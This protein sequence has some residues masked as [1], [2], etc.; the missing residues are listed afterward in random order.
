LTGVPPSPVTYSNPTLPLSP[1]AALSPHDM[2]EEPPGGGF[3]LPTAP[4]GLPG[5]T[6]PVVTSL[7][8]PPT[9]PPAALNQPAAAPSYDDLAARFAALK[10]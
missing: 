2:E 6:R 7:P 10:K 3:Q 4:S 9:A 8:T 1:P 5:S